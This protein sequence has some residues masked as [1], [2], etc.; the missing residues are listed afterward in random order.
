MSKPCD[1]CSLLVENIESIQFSGAFN[2]VKN[3]NNQSNS[4]LLPVYLDQNGKKFIFF[5][6]G[7]LHYAEQFMVFFALVIP[8]NLSHLQYK[9][10]MF[11]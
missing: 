9:K 1:S 2:I 6:N 8:N 11:M 4:I 7:L 3:L 5:V 10:P